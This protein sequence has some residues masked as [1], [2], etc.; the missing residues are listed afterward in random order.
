MQK[1]ALIIGIDGVPFGLTTRMME[2]GYMKEL[3]R[4]CDEGYLVHKMRASYPDISSVSW[5]SFMTGANPGEHGIFGF[6]DLKP[7]SYDL[8]FPNSRD[9]K[10]PTFWQV[11]REQGKANRA[12]VLNIPNTY[13]AFPID[14]LLVSG[15]V[16]IDFTKA[17]YPPSYIAPLQRMGYIID[18]D[19]MKVREDKDA[20]YQ[21][22]VESLA[23]RQNVSKKLITEEEWDISVICVTETDRLHHFFYDKKDSIVFQDFYKRVDAFIANT[24]RSF[25]AK[26]GTEFLFLILSDHGFTEQITEVNLNAYLKDK[27]FLVTNE[28]REYYDK[29]DNGTTAF[30][31]DP[32][33]IY[34]HHEKKFPRGQVKP[35]EVE[36]VKDRVKG[37]LLGLTDVKGTKVIREILSKDDIYSGPYYDNAPD[38]ICISHEGYDLKGNLR[39]K[40]VF[41]SDIFKGMHTGDDATLIAPK[42]VSFDRQVTIEDPARIIIDYFS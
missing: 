39:K 38:L 9:I 8:Y 1:K 2:Q 13:P 41:S 23:I 11:L 18:V 25:E 20:F 10:A 36:Q 5:T 7:N 21:D 30:A 12:L 37:A 3:K 29:I 31:M 4:I 40:E 34:I 28:N 26:Y 14:G 32:G 35:S 24:Y 6:T 42:G 33:R 16:A 19:L 22:L 15:F 27:G 17:V